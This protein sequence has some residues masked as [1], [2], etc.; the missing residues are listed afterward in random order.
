[1]LLLALAGVQILSVTAALA[2]DP[3]CL[4]DATMCVHASHHHHASH[5]AATAAPP[6]S[7]GMSHCAH[8]APASA[9][10]DCSMRGCGSHREEL[11][12]LSAL[13]SMPPSIAVARLEVMTA[14]APVAVRSLL[15][16][17]S[18][19]EPPPPRSLPA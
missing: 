19:V 16:R 14:L 9:P 17:P 18:T 1:V 4:C 3:A 6:A 12:P 11:L 5:A 7:A 8:D 15:D 13:G 10:P 2:G